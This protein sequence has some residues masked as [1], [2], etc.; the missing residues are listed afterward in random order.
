[1]DQNLPAKS[2]AVKSNP[3]TETMIKIQIEIN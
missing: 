2:P 1:M 3:E